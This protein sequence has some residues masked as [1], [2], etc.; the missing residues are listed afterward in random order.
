MYDCISCIKNAVQNKNNKC[1]W[2]KHKNIIMKII[3][4]PSPNF[5][6]SKYTKVGVQIH[7]TLGLMPST[8]GWLRNPIAWASCHFLI[9]KSGDIHQLVQTKD[10][11]WS[12]GRINRPSE[13]AKKI[14]LKTIWGSYVKPGHYLIQIEYECL[15]H[16]TFTEKQYEASVWLFNQFSFDITEDNF[17]EHQDTAVDKPEL[18]KERAETLR[19]LYVPKESDSTRLV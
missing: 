1:Y 12:S 5:S 7:K 3:Q 11:S 6:T 10:R 8:L 13:R 17:L 2:C 16:E 4:S 15:L 9:T 14:M 18:E 19:R